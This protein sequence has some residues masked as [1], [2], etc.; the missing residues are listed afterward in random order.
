MSLFVHP[1]ARK[2]LNRCARST[3]EIIRG[4]TQGAF[5]AAARRSPSEPVYA[6]ALSSFY[7]G[8]FPEAL[9]AVEQAIEADELRAALYLLRGEILLRM[10]RTDEAMQS[11]LY[12]DFLNPESP[13]VW[14]Q[15]AL[16]KTQQSR[17]DEGLKLVEA[18]LKLGESDPSI[19]FRRPQ[20]PP[21][22]LVDVPPR[23]PIEKRITSTNPLLS[24]N[25][26]DRMDLPT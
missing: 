20:F 9:Q 7:G 12:A 4:R 6:L 19:S 10:N 16:L 3:D 21:R 14:L 26:P 25:T 1:E 8:Q 24:S 5:A 11:L 22:R 13:A 2:V 18:A 17:I 23:K 15:I